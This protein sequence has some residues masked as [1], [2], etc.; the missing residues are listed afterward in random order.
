M[1]AQGAFEKFVA[2]S[3]PA[4]RIHC[5]RLGRVAIL[6]YEDHIR[7]TLIEACH[8]S[9]EADRFFRLHLDKPELLAILVRIA[10]DDDDYGGDAPMTAA[11]YVQSFL[12]PC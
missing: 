3:G 7:E 11:Y 9:D 10:K 5:Y 12:H 6:F 8:S 1:P 4:R 2:C